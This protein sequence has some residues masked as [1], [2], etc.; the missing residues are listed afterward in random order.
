[1]ITK[2]NNGAVL[3][4]TKLTTVSPHNCESVI[5]SVVESTNVLCPENLFLRKSQTHKGIISHYVDIGHLCFRHWHLLWLLLSTL[6]Y[7]AMM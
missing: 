7:F 3:P 6:R 5:M 2:L 1:V 4:F